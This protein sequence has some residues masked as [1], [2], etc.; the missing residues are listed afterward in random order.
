MSLEYLHTKK[1]LA[2]LLC[3]P[4]V[5]VHC[6][7][8][9]HRRG[10]P[11]YCRVLGSSQSISQRMTE[12]SNCMVAKNRYPSPGCSS[13]YCREGTGCRHTC[14]GNRNQRDAHKAEAAAQA[15]GEGYL[16]VKSKQ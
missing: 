9:S 12:P 15:P 3:H 4:R 5:I 6:P 16:A 14:S 11:R 13:T 2:T 7:P 1:T 8:T 10:F